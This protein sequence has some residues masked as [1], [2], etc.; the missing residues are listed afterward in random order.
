MPQRPFLFIFF[1][2]FVAISLA[3]CSLLTP[4]QPK[5]V[6]PPTTSPTAVTAEPTGTAP[7][8]P[9]PPVP[10]IFVPTSALPG[11]SLY[12]TGQQQL[13]R[14][15]IRLFHGSN[16]DFPWDNTVTIAATGES[17]VTIDMVSSVDFTA[18]DITGE[19][20][21]DVI[22]Q[23]YTGG[24]HCCFQT[25]IYDVGSS[26]TPVL[27]T[28]ISNCS[29]QLVDISGDGMPEFLTCDD[30]FAYTFCAFAGSPMPK[31]LLQHQPGRGFVPASS[32]YPEQYADAIVRDRL[33][34]ENAS[35]NSSPEEVRCA[36]LHLVLDYLYSG[37]QEEGW[38]ALEQYY[39]LDDLDD[40]RQE[41]E[42]ILMDSS[43][44]QQ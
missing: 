44:F 22:I 41:I 36:V 31:V 3:G 24:A 8:T 28:P 21:P 30:S 35:Q 6:N 25:L 23:R 32:S 26:L 10:T 39:P 15:M 33:T 16:P 13:G 17:P 14:Y 27:T 20:N 37:Q 4:F 29:G 5:Q 40:F 38:A 9:P 2:L 34:A 18:A 7:F 11:Y 1:F 12:L 42:S 43:Y 19:G